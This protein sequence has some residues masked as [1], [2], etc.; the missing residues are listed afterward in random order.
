MKTWKAIKLSAK[1]GSQ[2][3]RNTRESSRFPARTEC[4]HQYPE[5]FASNLEIIQLSAHIRRDSRLTEV[6]LSS[7]KNILRRL[8]L[9]LLTKWEVKKNM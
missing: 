5:M 1:D 9:L 7:E 2:T 4:L 3:L 8:N 6:L